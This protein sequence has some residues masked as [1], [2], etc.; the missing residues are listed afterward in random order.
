[1]RRHLGIT[2]I[3]TRIIVIDP[4]L[5]G[6]NNA[7]VVDTD[8]LPL[9]HQDSLMKVVMGEGQQEDIKLMDLLSRTVFNSGMPMLTELH[10][11]GSLYRYDIDNIEMVIDDNGNRRPLREVL[12]MAAINNNEVATENP[13]AVND[14]V[15]PDT[16]TPVSK[17]AYDDLVGMITSMQ[18]QLDTI[19]KATAPKK[20]GRPAKTVSDAAE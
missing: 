4:Q 12:G 15:N 1:M 7:L 14:T 20:R 8:A 5:S 11:S 6:S 17:P 10:S 13:E 19:I 2:N 9:K 3:G 16:E 18:E